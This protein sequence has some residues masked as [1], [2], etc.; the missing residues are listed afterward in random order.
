M[1][2]AIY[3]KDDRPGVVRIHS[4]GGP[5][6]VPLRS[7]K[8]PSN[9]AAAVV[10]TVISGTESVALPLAAGELIQVTG[11]EIVSVSP[12]SDLIYWTV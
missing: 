12:A 3:S 2:D 5:L 4:G 11:T 10:A 9:A 8:L 7:I 1:S 6:K